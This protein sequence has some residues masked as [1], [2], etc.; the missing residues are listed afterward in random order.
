M[1]I[2]PLSI[3]DHR[4]IVLQ[5]P[6][7]LMLHTS[8]RLGGQPSACSVERSSQPLAASHALYAALWRSHHPR[9]H[10]PWSAAAAAPATTRGAATSRDGPSSSGEALLDVQGLCASVTGGGK[11]MKRAGGSGGAGGRQILQGVSLQVRGGEVHALMGP[12]GCG[13]S[14]LAKVGG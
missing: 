7:G 13:K 4:S 8:S 6:E 14:T 10:A 2:L 9:H 12:N 5:A 1:Q 11:S 3:L